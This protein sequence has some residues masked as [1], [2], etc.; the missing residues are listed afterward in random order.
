LNLTRLRL[1]IES[2]IDERE[3]PL[4]I[5]LKAEPVKC[6]EIQLHEAVD[7]AVA[8]ERGEAPSPVVLVCDHAS[9][10]LPS[11]YDSLGL[12]AENRRKHF[13]WDP[14]ALGL[15]R[16]L[17]ELL[18]APLV[19]GCVSRLILDVNRRPSDVDSIVEAA[20]G[21]E[22][23]GNVGLPAD[24][25]ERRVAEV[26]APYHAAIE[27]LLANRAKQGRPSALI[28]IHTY[29][30]S[31]HGVVRPWHCGVIFARD[32]RIGKA[33]VKGLRSEVGLLVGVNEPYAPSDRVYHTM[34]RHG[35]ANGHPAAMIEVRNDLVAESDG[36]EAWAARLAPL[37]KATAQ[38]SL[39]AAPGPLK[40][41][42]NA[43]G[44]GRHGNTREQ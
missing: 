25:R 41:K 39:N 28:A 7:P 27:D 1:K 35:E 23:P 40:E 4:R 15:S 13:A 36:Q 5:P 33:L 9:N 2:K 6:W 16:H 11:R 12:T 29:T 42:A 21:V 43:Y 14:G 3:R 44:A 38:M 22:V 34:L 10:H 31:L 17:S 18:D 30:P 32:S 26:Y 19:Y 8:V 37:L 20:D 24:E